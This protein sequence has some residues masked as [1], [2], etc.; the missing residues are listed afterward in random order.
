MVMAL[1]F[2]NILFYL[3]L[4]PYPTFAAE[5]LTPV[6]F[7]ALYEFDFGNIPIGRM[8]IEIEQTPVHY[9]I[10]ADIMTTGIVKLF[11]K[12]SSHTTVDASGENFL[13]PSLDYESNYQTKKKKKYVHFIYKNGVE[14]QETLV[15][16][17]NRQT[18]PEVP[19][20]LKK[21]AAD[22]LSFLLR[23]RQALWQ[24]WRDGEKSFTINAYDGRRLYEADFTVKGKGTIGYNGRQMPVIAVDVKRKPLAGFTASEMA[25]F[26]HPEPVL[27]VYFSD[28]ERML[29]IRLEA[30]AF[31]GT[32]SA[33]LAKECRTGESCLLGI[34]D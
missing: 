1:R 22:P 9:D 25:E 31:L 13:Y 23:M 19:A 15:P 3:I 5:A 11:V 12:H 32:I 26:D 20:D 30:S 2:F 33:T 7:K 18:R 10:A 6:N 27:H 17:E 4:L 21:N 8:G 14:T 24:A 29:P 28:D 34:K 16:P